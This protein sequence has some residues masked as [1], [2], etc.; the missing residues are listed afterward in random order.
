MLDTHNQCSD[1]PELLP[2]VNLN[3]QIVPNAQD[4]IPTTPK[5]TNAP[6]VQ[7]PMDVVSPPQEPSDAASIH[8]LPVPHVTAGQFPPVQSLTARSTDHSTSLENSNMLTA[9]TH[10]DRATSFRNNRRS[11]MDVS[12]N[13][14]LCDLNDPYGIL[15]GS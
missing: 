7:S 13:Y 8:S 9:T 2:D 12:Y 5:I 10:L 6:V 4:F 11:V 1:P 15:S 3:S 14:Q